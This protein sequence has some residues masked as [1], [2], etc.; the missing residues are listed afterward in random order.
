MGGKKG[1]GKK[2]KPAAAAVAVDPSLTK[3]HGFAKAGD[4]PSMEEHGMSIM[5]LQYTDGLKRVPLHLAAFGGHLAIVDRIVEICPEAA[6]LAAQDGY[7]PIH[8]AAQQGHIECVRSLVR[9]AGRSS[10]NPDPKPGSVKKLM[11]RVVKGER[12]LLHLCCARN[13][14]EVAC[15]LLDKGCDLQ[16]RQTSNNKNPLELLSPENQGKVRQHLAAKKGALAEDAA[17]SAAIG[18]AGTAVDDAEMPDAEAAD[19]AAGASSSGVGVSAPG[20]GVAGAN[21]AQ[22]DDADGARVEEEVD[23]D[24]MAAKLLALGSKKKK[25]KRDREYDAE[26]EEKEK[27]Q[28]KVEED[29]FALDAVLRDSYA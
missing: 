14:V 5:N 21:N 16:A 11:G 26:D 19:S 17:V 20:D 9:A 22:R 7:L 12:N 27:K 1:N 3:L 4:L 13:H 18:E 8:F 25:K 24:A 6:G 15:F 23:A 10:I 29:P 2:G 28:T